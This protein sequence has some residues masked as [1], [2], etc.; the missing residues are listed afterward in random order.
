[1]PWPAG[2]LFHLP[3][4]FHTKLLRRIVL[5][6]VLHFLPFHLFLESLEFI[7]HHSTETALTKAIKDLFIIIAQC[8]LSTPQYLI[9]PLSTADIYSTSSF[10]KTNTSSLSIHTSLLYW[11]CSCCLS[12]TSFYFSAHFLHVN[13]SILNTPLC[14]SVRI[15]P[16]PWFQC[17]WHPNAY[18]QLRSLASTYLVSLYIWIW[19][20]GYT[21]QT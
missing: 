5:S 9:W 16:L 20:C 4:S 8:L 13:I 2:R 14:S 6:S 10:L 19:V 7:L 11:V 17:R 3:S 21:L 15:H 1:M 18:C 12:L